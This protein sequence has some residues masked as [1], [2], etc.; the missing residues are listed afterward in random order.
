MTTRT[1]EEAKANY[2]KKMGETLGTQFAALFQEVAWLHMVWGEF[3]E[4]FRDEPRVTVL[5]EAAPAMFHMIRD[6]LWQ[7]TLLDLARLTDP[8]KSMGKENLT[9][10]NLSELVKPEMRADV[11]KLVEAAEKKSDFCRDY[12]NRRIAHFDLTLLTDESAKPLE[13]AT[14]KAVDEALAAIGSVL[15]EVSLHYMGPW[16]HFTP[17]VGGAGN[18]LAL[19]R[20]LQHGLIAR[21]WKL[22][23]Q[24]PF[25]VAHP[26]DI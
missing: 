1:A 11:Q 14:K 18:A 17:N 26:G 24:L 21:K 23:D 2:I 25:E 5:N 9:I 3:I 22:L 10:K 16:L 20:L 6:A 7:F 13:G 19:L 12:R 8:P 4:L 15:S